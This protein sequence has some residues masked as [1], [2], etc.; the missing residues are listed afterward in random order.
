MK[1]D[2]YKYICDQIGIAAKSRVK[3]EEHGIRT[4]N[5]LLAVKSRIESGEL[6]YL[7][8]EVRKKLIKVAEW[9]SCN[10]DVDII[11]GFDEDVFEEF[12]NSKNETSVSEYCDSKSMDSEMKVSSTCI[13]D[14]FLFQL[15]HF[16]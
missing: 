12:C 15:C 14:V 8:E 11:Q 13:T 6:S 9:R 10:L 5:D 1:R 7:R 2:Y 3:I 16:N 4:E